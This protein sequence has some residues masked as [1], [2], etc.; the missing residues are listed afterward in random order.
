L[1]RPGIDNHIF[2]DARW[3]IKTFR[4]LLKSLNIQDMPPPTFSREVFLDNKRDWIIQGMGRC[5][6]AIEQTSLPPE[7]GGMLLTHHDA[8]LDLF[9]LQI[10]INSSLCKTNSFDER[11]DRKI[12]AVHEFTHA[13]AFLSAISRVRSKHIIER[14]IKKFG[15]KAHT[16]DLADIKQISEDMN[17]PPAK[18]QQKQITK[19]EFDDKHF[20][21]EF[22]DF[23]VSYPV[24][25]NE[26]LFSKEMFEEYF[27]QYEI[28]AMCKACFKKDKQTLVD[29][30][31]PRSQKIS[32]EKALNEKFVRTRIGEILN[33]IYSEFVL[34]H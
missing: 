6:V 22:E 28:Q 8:D 18:K 20:R 16:I 31:V 3:A 17:R 25:F 26:F 19:K 34:S 27:T 9:S 15:E 33:P 24:I 10:V 13:V 1:L 5:S 11:V 14:L 32:Q 7:N 4:P 2:R 21:L 30:I 23:P 29:L 12:T